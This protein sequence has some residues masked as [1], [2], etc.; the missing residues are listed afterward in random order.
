MSAGLS[1]FDKMAE[2]CNCH[3]LLVGRYH[4]VFLS[5]MNSVNVT[6]TAE[7]YIVI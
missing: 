5:S 3:L 1:L 4:N 2:Y 7:Y 6:C